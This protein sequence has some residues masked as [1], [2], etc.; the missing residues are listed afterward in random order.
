MALKRQSRNG[1]E[2]QQAAS[3]RTLLAKA[4]QSY[5]ERA[6]GRISNADSMLP[7]ATVLDASPAAD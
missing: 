1:P 5:A 2:A 3:G 6:D 4:V 7:E